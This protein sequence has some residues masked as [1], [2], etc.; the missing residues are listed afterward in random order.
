MYNK[1]KYSVAALLLPVMLFAGSAPKKTTKPQLPLENTK[2]G[3]VYGADS[4]GNRIPDFSYSGY[5]AGEQAIPNVFAKV[6]V[7]AKTGDGTARIQAAIDYVSSL[8]PDKSGFRGAVLL[9]PGVFEIDGQLIIRTSGVVLRG[10]GIGENGTKLVATG[11]DRRTL[12][13]VVGKDDRTKAETLKVADAYVPVNAMKLTLKNAGSLKAGD[14]IMVRRPSTQ[15]WIEALGTVTFGGG[16]SALGWKPGDRD[17]YWDRT[18]VAINGNEITLDAPLTTALDANYGGGEVIPY[19]WNGRIS[20]VGIE[21]MQCTSTVDA[22]NPKDEAHAW[23]AITLENVIDGWVRQITFSH[24]A[25]SAVMALATSRRLTVEDCISIDPVSEL[26]GQRRYT[27]FNAGQQSL[28]QRLYAE[29]GNHDFGIGF[30]AAGP[31]AFVQCQ[32]VL[33]YSF[34]GAIDSWTSGVL[35]DI[36]N[37]DGNNLRFSNRQQD[38][39]GTGWSAANSVFY[40]C[41]AALI[42]CPKPPTAQNWAFGC[43]SQFGGDGGWYDSNNQIQPRSLYYAQLAKRIGKQATDRAF[44]INVG[45]E[46]SNPSVEVAQQLTQD[47]KKIAFTILNLVQSAPNRTPI[48]IEAQGIKSIDEIGVPTSNIIAVT[49]TTVI[50]GKL[51]HGDQLLAGMQHDTPWWNGSVLP[52]F[53]DEAKPALTR[54]VPGRT[55][56]GLTDDVTEVT[57]WMKKNNIVAF[58]QHYGLWTD[59]RRDDHERIR[60]IDGDVWPPFYE[61]PFARSGQGTAWDGLSK[62]DLTKYNTWYWLR[63]KQ[64]ADQADQN[65]LVLFNN[66][67]F[68]HNI[69][70]AGAHWVDC[71]WRT[72]N[73]INGTGFPEPINFAGDKRIFFAEM[74]Y[75]TTNVV[76]KELYRKYIRQCLNNFS[77][78]SAVVQLTSDEYTGPLHFMQFWLDVISDWEKETGKHPLIGLSATKDV[79]DAILKD[80]KRAAVV[81]VV[82]I[83]YWW[84][85]AQGE[86]YTPKGGINLAPRQQERLAKPKKTSFE[87]VYR[88][89]NEYRTQCPGKAVMYYSDS[90]PVY[91]WAV[92]MAGGSLP[93]LPAGLEKDFLKDAAQ[94]S[95]VKSQSETQYVLG[96][97]GKGYI[98]YSKNG[99]ATLDLSGSTKTYV[100]KWIDPAT[101]V[102]MPAGKVKGGNTVTLK[103]P[104][105]GTTVL[106]LSAK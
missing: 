23:M 44:V 69:I 101:G 51:V 28:F 96:N 8:K 86:L 9:Q 54:F 61:Q 53:L 34:S 48:P 64:F 15:N 65:G 62:Y 76:R 22:T 94:M 89:V 97:Q 14:R 77:D 19:S 67:F 30:C 7:P 4:L 57:E 68:Q 79:Q 98:V 33:P 26:G 1:V 49:P 80:S 87:Q 105:S 43:W 2:E 50:N 13:R 17:I 83:R 31:N 56:T 84:Y 21:N 92:L 41:S 66:N 35:F 63:L 55:G 29:G 45:S 88:A 60:R 6:V 46:S 10:S 16:V 78:N 59:R 104:K 100:A 99:E 103:A 39:R 73:N 106:W 37:V 58:E 93:N 81:D 32:S 27:F 47:A 75:D 36:V 24:F 82:D 12:I 72:A 85:Q 5:M 90:Y 102:S 25:G 91:G 38:N 11:K 70:E 18:V 95:V 71:P 74:F 40:Q 52:T 20:Q 3:L 42:D